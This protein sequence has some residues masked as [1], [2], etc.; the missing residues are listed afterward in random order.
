MKHTK[1]IIKQSA[2]E[3]NLKVITT[4]DY[5]HIMYLN[6]FSIWYVYADTTCSNSR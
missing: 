1:I 3:D 4:Q 2:L 6:C 5:I